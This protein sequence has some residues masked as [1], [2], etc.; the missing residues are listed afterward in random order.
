VAVARKNRTDEQQAYSH[1][2]LAGLLVDVDERLA[3]EHLG[4][5][6]RLHKE[7]AA[8]DSVSPSD[9]VWK[10]A[11]AAFESKDFAGAVTI[12][13]SLLQEIPETDPGWPRLIVNPVSTRA[14]CRPD[15]QKLRGA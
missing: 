6:I 10:K 12:Y 1:R 5:Y 8:T 7:E 14:M 11:H 4:E 2:A 13:E 3:V 15:W 9:A